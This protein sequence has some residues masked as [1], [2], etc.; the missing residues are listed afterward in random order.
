[1]SVA[2]NQ[3]IQLSIK[4][5]SN[6]YIDLKFVVYPFD[7]NNSIE[8]IDT[9]RNV[10]PIIITSNEKVNLDDIEIS[11][12]TIDFVISLTLKTEIRS[13]TFS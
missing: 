1:V 2:Y 13:G 7:K 4:A 9:I 8:N 12:V 6:M 10:K 3:V 11:K 5:E